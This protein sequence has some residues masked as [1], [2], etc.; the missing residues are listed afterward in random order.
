MAGKTVQIVQDAAEKTLAV[1]VVDN[2]GVELTGEG[3]VELKLDDTLGT[4]GVKHTVVLQQ[5][6]VCV[7][8]NRLAMIGAFS[9]LFDP[10]APTP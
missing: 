2:D 6:L 1:K 10:E 7:Q 9:E 3:K 4:D 8:G 5:V